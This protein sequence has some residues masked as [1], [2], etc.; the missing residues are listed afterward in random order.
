VV[1]MVT[2]HPSYGY[3]DFVEG[4]KPVPSSGGGLTLERA[5][6]VFMR[7]C[8]QAATA[9]DRWFLL[10]IDE[11][12]RGDLPR[13]LGDVVTLLERDKRDLPVRLPVSGRSFAVPSN[14]LVIGTMNTADRSIGHIDAAIR[15]RFH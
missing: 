13:V 15:R 4:F 5:D 6:G 10:V 12:N 14:V 1:S 3:E 11:I 2:F 8:R 7:L 9:P